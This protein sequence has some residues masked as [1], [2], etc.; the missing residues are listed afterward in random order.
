MI[1]ETK[2][3]RNFRVLAANLQN[4][5]NLTFKNPIIDANLLGGAK[6]KFRERLFDLQ[7]I[8]GV[9]EDQLND[10]E[11]VLVGYEN[12]INM[13]LLSSLYK[14]DK[15]NQDLVLNNYRKEYKKINDKY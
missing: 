4:L 1:E 13:F 15:D 6:N 10:L 11:N 7:N 3:V 2:N 14:K 5:K 12:A 9:V 8:I